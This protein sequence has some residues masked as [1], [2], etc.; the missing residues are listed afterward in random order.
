MHVAIEIAQQKIFLIY[1]NTHVKFDVT[2]INRTV[3]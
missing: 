2:S 3:V 1:T